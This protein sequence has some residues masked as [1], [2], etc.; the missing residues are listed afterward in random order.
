MN[1]SNS[2]R[3][4][5]QDLAQDTPCCRLVN[6]ALWRI[7]VGKKSRLLNP[8]PMGDYFTLR[9]S[10]GLITYMPA[11]RTQQIN[12]DGSWKREGRQGIKPAKWLR[13][14]LAPRLAKRI[15][16][17]VFADFAT[18]FRASEDAG[19]ITFEFVTF[20]EAYNESNFHDGKIQ[21][22][23]W[24]EPVAAFYECFPCRVLVARDAKQFRGRAIV[25]DT[26]HGLAMPL[27]DRV[28]A[29][30]PEVQEAFFRHAAEQGWT[31]KAQQNNT[32]FTLFTSPSGD[33][34]TCRADTLYIKPTSDLG[35]VE[36]WPYMD[37]F[38]AMSDCGRCYNS[39]NKDGAAYIL[40]CT[41]GDRE[42]VDNHE[43]EVLCADG[44][45]RDGDNVVCVDGE[46]YAYDDEDVVY[47][48]RSQEHIMRS[49]AYEVDMGGRIGT[50]YVHE[51]YVNRA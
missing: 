12:A 34:V 42:E 24:G 36:F 30:S 14:V 1:I 3:T 43:G 40:D 9:E 17:H 28:Y 23:M 37:T 32:C 18:K 11:G 5:L 7:K 15:P 38:R 31:R 39:A 6:R 35:D 33:G 2:L 50:V 29:D 16:D 41:N 22:C 51:D 8:S 26:V 10:E 13:A 27:M 4:L 44:E 21:S 47:C 19:K 48:H 25:W 20:A 45:W 49:D 46:Y